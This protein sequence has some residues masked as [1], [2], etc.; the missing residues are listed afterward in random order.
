MTGPLEVV[1]LVA[2]LSPASHRG[3]VAIRDNDDS[4][5]DDIGDDADGGDDDTCTGHLDGMWNESNGTN[6]R[7]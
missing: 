1:L 4:D 7:H 3:G 2:H 6:P 5:S